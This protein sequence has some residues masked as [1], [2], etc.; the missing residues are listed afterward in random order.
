[1][2]QQRISLI[3][4]PPASCGSLTI[5]QRICLGRHNSL[6]EKIFPIFTASL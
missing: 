4:S 1:M 2:N 3:F 6:A 5:S